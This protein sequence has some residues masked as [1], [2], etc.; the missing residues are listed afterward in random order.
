VE[1]S[2]VS[3]VVCPRKE[4][5]FLDRYLTLWIFLAMA[6][7]VLLGYIAPGVVPA[8]NQMSIGTTSIPIAVGLILMMYPPLVKVK[9]RGSGSDLPQ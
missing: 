7:G 5:S 9:I 4:L 6:G 3:S 1:N 8:L 2:L